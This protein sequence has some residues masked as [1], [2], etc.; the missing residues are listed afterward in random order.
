MVVSGEMMVILSVQVQVPGTGA[1]DVGGT[2]N[3][4]LHGCGAVADAT[5]PKVGLK[6]IRE[7]DPVG[8]SLA[9]IRRHAPGRH[10]RRPMSTRRRS[11]LQVQVQV[12]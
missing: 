6:I 12:R 3:A 8:V 10:A 4:P 9:P 5:H 11:L 7:D 1:G 2:R